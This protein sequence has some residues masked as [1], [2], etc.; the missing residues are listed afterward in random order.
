MSNLLPAAIIASIFFISWI[1]LFPAFLWEAM[2]FR[3]RK[4]FID[5]LVSIATILYFLGFVFTIV[6]ITNTFIFLR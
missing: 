5:V 6:Y 4:G 1:V 2:T 3:N